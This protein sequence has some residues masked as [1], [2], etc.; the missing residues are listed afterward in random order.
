MLGREAVLWEVGQSWCK[1]N[2]ESGWRARRRGVTSES[3]SVLDFVKSGP[4]DRDRTSHGGDD[5]SIPA[6]L[7]QLR[8]A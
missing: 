3:A 5:S 4:V 7:A 6:R 1:R 2:M 8:T